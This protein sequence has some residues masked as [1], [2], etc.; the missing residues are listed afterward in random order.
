MNTSTPLIRLGL[1]ALAC[2][3]ILG[4]AT[5]H[6]SPVS[7]APRTMPALPVVSL[8]T[9]T[10]R[11]DVAEPL[12]LPMASSTPV[13]AT[14]HVR[15][16]EEEVLAARIDPGDRIQI[17]APIVIR[18]SADEVATALRATAVA[19]VDDN[20]EHGFLARVVTDPHRLRLD[21]PYYSFGKI[22]TRSH[23]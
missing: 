2:A 6:S 21:M 19:E 7:L 10:V 18:P 8:G 15:A 11:P 12:A 3:T 23:K 22:L 13:L 5:L 4:A 20:D 1:L 9:V 17:L 14:V 16:S